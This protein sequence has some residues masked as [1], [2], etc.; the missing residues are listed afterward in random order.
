VPKSGLPAYARVALGLENILR[1]RGL[2]APDGRPL[3]SY[4]LT[5]SE[6]AALRKALTEVFAQR[7]SPCLDSKWCSYAFVAVAGHRVTGRLP[8][9]FERQTAY[10]SVAHWTGCPKG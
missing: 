6:I 5:S 3:Y 1:A 7:G 9:D 8:D 2:T 10:P 4:K